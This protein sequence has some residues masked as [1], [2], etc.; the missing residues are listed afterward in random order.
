MPL[1]MLDHWDNPD[2][3]VERGYAGRS[4]FD[5]WQLPEHLDPRLIDYARA[6]ASIG[7]NGVV[8]NNVNASPLF[9]TDALH[10]QAR[11]RWPTPGGPMASALYLSA[12]FSRA[13]RS[14]RLADR[15]P[16]R[17]GGAGV[18]EGARPTRSTPRSPTSA[19]SWSRP[20]PKASRARRTIGRTHAEG[21]NMLAARARAAAAW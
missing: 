7:I 14:R 18:V 17:P 8:V 11:A 10:P 4:I 19:A 5:W 3:N 12:R 6:N 2:G 9:L 21:A 15:R 1:R 13:E 20:T 16:A